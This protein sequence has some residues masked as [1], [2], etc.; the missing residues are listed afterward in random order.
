[1]LIKG[2]M[3]VGGAAIAAL[4]CTAAVAGSGTAGHNLYGNQSIAAGRLGDA[5]RIL[6]PASYA[7]ANDP[8]RLINIATVYAQTSRFSDARRALQR[9]MKLPDEPLVL[10]NG[11]NFSSRKLA[12]AMLERMPQDK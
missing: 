9:V 6:R 1:M 5:E 4:S 3:M 2:L 7:D 8:G 11:A 12:W 10:A